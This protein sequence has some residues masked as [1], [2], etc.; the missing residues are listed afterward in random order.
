MDNTVA[1]WSLKGAEAVLR[2]RSLYISGER[3]TPILFYGND[4][5]NPLSA[6]L[7]KVLHIL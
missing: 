1:R 3:A 5:I 2:L 7:H 6:L 4:L